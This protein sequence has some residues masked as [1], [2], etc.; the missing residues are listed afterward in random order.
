MVNPPQLDEALEV[1]RVYP[2][3][4]ADPD[5]GQLAP[6]DEQIHLVP[7]EGEIVGHLGDREELHATRPGR[8]LTTTTK[9]AHSRP[10]A[11]TYSHALIAGSR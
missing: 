2:H 5:A 1:A 7:G 3:A 8:K 6:L 11:T 9:S 10:T 4:A